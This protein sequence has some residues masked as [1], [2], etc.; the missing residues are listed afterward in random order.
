M[1]D[2]PHDPLIDDLRT[3][4]AKDDS[5]PPLVVETAKASLG[6]RRLDADLAELL[7]DSALE[8]AGDFAL[9]RGQAQ[10]R[11]VSFAAGGL[12]IDLEIQGEAPDRRLLGQ[13]SPP[14][15]GTIELQVAAGGEAASVAQADGLGRFRLALPETT[16]F[17]LRVRVGE[18]SAPD[19]A[20]LTE[21]SWVPL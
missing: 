21:T 20:A 3:L 2:T 1:Y 11:S 15:A 7:S 9:A 8:P 17:R 13:I 14:V 5:V 4:F 6:W 19:A 10:M 18:P 12:T 16:A